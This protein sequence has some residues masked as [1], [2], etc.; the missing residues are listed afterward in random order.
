MVS[1][2]KIESLGKK[3]QEK[4]IQWYVEGIHLQEIADRLSS[5][6]DTYVSLDNVKKFLQRKKDKSIKILKEDEHLQSQLVQKYFDSLQQLNKLNQE[7]WQFFYDLKQQTFEE[8]TIKCPNCGEPFKL[9][10]KDYKSLIKVAEH[11][12]N[13]IKHVDAVVGKLNKKQLTVTYN[14][15]D[16]SKK[17]TVAV[18]K[19]LEGLEQ[20]GVVKI[21]KKKLKQIYS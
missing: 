18:P 11:I 8:K 21:N 1:R 19:I 14:I 20:R 17:L 10:L 2:G 16:L 4:T 5:E 7:M 15:Y 6:Y 12:L 3:A 13:Q 9:K